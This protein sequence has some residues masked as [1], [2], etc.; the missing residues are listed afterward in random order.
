MSDG[1]FGDLMERGFVSA[2][3]PLDAVGEREPWLTEVALPFWREMAKRAD[4]A[5]LPVLCDVSHIRWEDWFEAVDAAVWLLHPWT[6]LSLSGGALARLPRKERS[7]G[8]RGVATQPRR[9][10]AGRSRVCRSER[11]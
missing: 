2:G 6:R 1:L 7:D 5:G 11:R 4:V 8:T 3:Q 9:R 10:S